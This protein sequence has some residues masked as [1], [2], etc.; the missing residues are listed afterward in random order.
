M[1]DDVQS[2]ADYFPM[3]VRWYGTAMFLGAPEDEDFVSGHSPA[4]QEAVEAYLNGTGFGP[5][6]NDLRFT[7]VQPYNNAWNRAVASE[8]GAILFARQSGGKWHRPDGS[9]VAPASQAYWEDAVLEKFKRQASG[10]RDAMRQIITDKSTGLRRQESWNEVHSRRIQQGEEQSKAARV[11]E[12][13]V[14]VLFRRIVI[15]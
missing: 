9:P 15:V 5:D 14:K 3:S 6:R 12:R 1:Q 13:R 8:L 10:W 7:D 4:P 2:L 11:R